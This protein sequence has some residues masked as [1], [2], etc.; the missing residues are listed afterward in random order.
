MLACFLLLAQRLL[1]HMLPALDQSRKSILLTDGKHPKSDGTFFQRREFC[2]TL[3]GDIFVRYQSFK[4]SRLHKLAAMRVQH[5]KAH[6]RSRRSLSQV[7]A[8]SLALYVAPAWLPQD[9]SE[10]AAALKDR[11]PSKIDIGPVYN[12]DP[13]RRAAYQGGCTHTGRQTPPEP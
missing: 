13:Q 9:G 6:L 8:S 10:M 11:C 7:Q 3:D 1:P 12:V 2:F 4:A 5:F